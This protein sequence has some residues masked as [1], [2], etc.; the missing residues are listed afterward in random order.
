[1]NSS[2]DRMNWISA[3][4]S[5]A[6]I[7]AYLL[8]PFYGLA[9]SSFSISGFRLI[10]LS[11]IAIVPVLLGILMTLGACLFPPLVAII[12]EAVTLVVMLVFMFM[13][14]VIAT[15]FIS[16]ALNLPA[17]WAQAINTT[18]TVLPMIQSSWGAVICLIMCVAALVCDVVVNLSSSTPPTTS[19]IL[20]TGE[21]DDFSNPFGSG[22]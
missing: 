17:E 18:Q 7:L 15:S 14:N 22:F 5:V 19:Y 21:N 8:A 13:G 9:L 12:V 3:W 6:M 2:R 1:M 10:G 16:S 20:G 4:F 11:P